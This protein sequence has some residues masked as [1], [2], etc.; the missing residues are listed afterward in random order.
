MWSFPALYFNLVT[1]LLKVNMWHKAA[2]Q[3]IRENTEDSQWS[4]A[5]L[6]SFIDI[7]NMAKG[8][9]NKY[10]QASV[11]QELEKTVPYYKRWREVRWK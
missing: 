1:N 2:M 9:M 8:L 6:S 4:S 11:Q 5:S 10:Q 7:V 3:S